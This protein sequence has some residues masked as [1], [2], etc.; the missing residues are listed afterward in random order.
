M[1]NTATQIKNGNTLHK[2]RQAV[3][4]ENS[5][6]SRFQR[7]ESYMETLEHLPSTPSIKFF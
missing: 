4:S 1:Q 2:N 7:S 6:P 5:L 3:A